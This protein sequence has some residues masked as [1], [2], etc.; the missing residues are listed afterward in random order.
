[1]KSKKALFSISLLCI[2]TALL[3]S[4]EST[5]AEFELTLNSIINNF[6]KNPSESIYGDSLSQISGRVQ[7]ETALLK[8][9]IA[10]RNQLDAWFNSTNT[11]AL[12]F[13][14]D[15]SIIYERYSQ[16]SD[17]GRNVNGMSLQKVITALLIG[18]AIEEKLIKSETDYIREYVKLELP[19]YAR[20]LTFH[21][22]LTHTSGIESSFSNLNQ[23][24][25]GKELNFDENPLKFT[26]TR[27]FKYDNMNYYLLSSILKNVYNLPLNKIIKKNIW[28]PLQLDK[29]HIQNSSGYCCLFATARSWLSIGKLFIDPNQPIIN[30]EWLG[31]MINSSINTGKFYVQA[32]NTFYGNKYGYHIY[33]GLAEYPNIFWMEG[34]GLQLLIINPIEKSIIVRLGDMPTFLSRQKIKRDNLLIHQLLS[35]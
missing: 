34:V 10:I 4:Q 8:S 21:N 14:R 1:M 2:L 32:T 23:T 18:I 17:S 25:S 35:I 5:Q 9:E 31:K 22:L 27:K 19:T 11:D 13:Y 7:D 20:D 3:I 26:E 15:D 29:A 6:L 24:L 28:G 12:I 30:P 16:R 33:S